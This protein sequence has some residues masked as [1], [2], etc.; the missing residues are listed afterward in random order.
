[1]LTERRAGWLTWYGRLGR[2]VTVE[3]AQQE[4]NV[5]GAELESAYP[6]SNQGRRFELSGHAAMT[7]GNG[8]ELRALL[9]LLFAAVCLMLAIA[10]GNVANLM[11]TRTAGRTR[12]MAIRLALGAGR[13]MLLRELLAE[14]LVL[15]AA[16]GALG[17]LLAPWMTGILS[18][19]WRQ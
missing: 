16:S 11:L 2:G 15:G 14:S 3:K 9:R 12:E 17:L 13:P 1:L 7:A 8:A 10:C 5:I 18:T 19:V 6:Q 4:W